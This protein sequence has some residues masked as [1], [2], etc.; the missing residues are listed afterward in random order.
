MENNSVFK[1]NHQQAQPVNYNYQYPNVAQPAP[2]TV[3]NT[4]IGSEFIEQIKR[5]GV[6]EYKVKQNRHPSYSG[7]QL[8]ANTTTNYMV[9]QTVVKGETKDC[10]QFCT[11]IFTNVIVW[12]YEKWAPFPTCYDVEVLLPGEKEPKEI[13]IKDAVWGKK[14]MIRILNDNGI[15]FFIKQ[16]ESQILRILMDH[17][18]NFFV[19]QSKYII[20][21]RAGWNGGDGQWKY[22]LAERWVIKEMPSYAVHKTIGNG[23]EKT[24]DECLKLC[25]EWLQSGCSESLRGIL[26]GL[27]LFGLNAS[28]IYQELSCWQ[29]HILVIRCSDERVKKWMKHFLCFFSEDAKKSLNF[30]CQTKELHEE[31]MAAKDQIIVIDGDVADISGRRKR[32]ITMLQDYVENGFLTSDVNSQTLVVVLTKGIMEGLLMDEAIIFDVKNCDFDKEYLNDKSVQQISSYLASGFIL[33]IEENAK[34]FIDTIRSKSREEDGGTMSKRLTILAEIGCKIMSSAVASGRFIADIN[35]IKDRIRQAEEWMD[36]DGLGIL[37]L[38]TMVQLLKGGQ[39]KFRQ[40]NEV[41]QVEWLEDTVFWDKEVVFISQDAIKKWILREVASDDTPVL[42]IVSAL[43]KGGYLKIYNSSSSGNNYQKRI[44][45]YDKMRVKYK[46]WMIAIPLGHFDKVQDG[47][48]ILEELKY[49][50]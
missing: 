23:I 37:V 38:E 28:R 14:E 43:Q 48:F 32:N 9:L 46:P 15:S 21:P 7:R 2:I 45:L 13:V 1:G 24:G 44:L 20:D 11:G 8:M 6:E 35:C 12:S 50:E 18:A 39:L 17:L 41:I 34:R 47:I 29:E 3:F 26:V 30:A 22:M 42:T 25:A 36:V 31:L 27:V 40:K 16:S 19:N 33:R 10:V 4:E 49:G 5:D